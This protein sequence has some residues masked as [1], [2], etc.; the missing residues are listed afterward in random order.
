M[1]TPSPEE[2]QKIFGQWMAWIQAM[3]ARGEYVGGGRLGDPGKV[4]RGPAGGTLSDGP[5]AEAKEVVGGY[6]LIAADNLEQ[7]ATIAKGCPGFSYGGS[8]EVR[9]VENPPAS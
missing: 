7:A 5:F 8:M 3:T 1:V 6:M 4:I 2:M 9:P